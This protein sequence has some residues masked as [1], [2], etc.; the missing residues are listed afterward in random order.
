MSRQYAKEK[1]IDEQFAQSLNQIKID[2]D[3]LD[4]IVSVMGASSAESKTT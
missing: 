4:W 3:V 2:D 1:N